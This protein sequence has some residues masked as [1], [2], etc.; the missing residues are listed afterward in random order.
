MDIAE[1]NNIQDRFFA[2]LSMR[3]TQARLI[4]ARGAASSRFAMNANCDWFCL[5]KCELLEGR[6][7]KLPARAVSVVFS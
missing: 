3:L 4:F 2:G 1:A 6:A 7:A 5:P